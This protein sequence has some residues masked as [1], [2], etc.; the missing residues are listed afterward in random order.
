MFEKFLHSLFIILISFL[1]SCGESN[2]ILQNETPPIEDGF[3]GFRWTTPMSIVDDE[4]PKRTGVKPVLTK[5][6]YN[7]SNFSDAYFLDQLTNLCVFHFN[8][9]GLSSV[10]IIFY[11][12]FRMSESKFYDLMEKLSFIYGKPEIFIGTSTD[13]NQLEFIGQFKWYKGR[14]NITLNTN[15][16]IEINAYGYYPVGI[17][18]NK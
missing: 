12:D 3:F 13:Q 14:L 9:R 15:Y 2:Y 10:K 18:H 16:D 6:H 5:N 7:T 8:E 4:F 1:L 11:T 17:I